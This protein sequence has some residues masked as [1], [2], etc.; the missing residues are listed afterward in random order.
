MH[1]DKSQSQRQKALA[2]FERG[3]VTVL[4]ATDVAARGIDV[5]EI[6]HVINFD[7][8]EDGDA[9]THR[10]GRTGR[11]GATG[12]GVSF[13]LGDQVHDMRRMAGVLGL[14]REFDARDGAGSAPPPQHDSGSR[15]GGGRNGGGRNGNGRNGTGRNQNGSHRS[16]ANT[17][18]KNK[19]G[20]GG[21]TGPKRQR[22]RPR[23][24]ARG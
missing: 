10:T 6:T 14:T 12:S 7:A 4:I 20:G 9:Y 11:A 22:R 2:R 24:T 23:Q 5:A 1:G 19:Q 21:S 8:P 18:R 16:N 3:D 17:A 15:N 13:V